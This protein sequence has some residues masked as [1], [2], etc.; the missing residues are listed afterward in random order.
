MF[1]DRGQYGPFN[2]VMVQNNVCSK[3]LVK[4]LQLFL[5]GKTISKNA[6]IGSAIITQLQ[7]YRLS[8]T[9]EKT[10]SE[11]FH[12]LPSMRER[13][14]FSNGYS[15]IQQRI[16]CRTPSFHVRLT[17]TTCDAQSIIGPQLQRSFNKAY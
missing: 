13:R 10:A 2:Y 17:V 12:V 16:F 9:F 5:I 6:K 8:Q 7:R 11:L 3:Y 15:G 4:N 14:A 1:A